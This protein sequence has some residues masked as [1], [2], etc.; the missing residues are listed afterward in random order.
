MLVLPNKVPAHLVNKRHAVA[1]DDVLSGV[2]RPLHP[3]VELV[4]GDKFDYKDTNDVSITGHPE[5]Q[6]YVVIVD[7]SPVVTRSYYDTAYSA[8]DSGPPKCMSDDGVIPAAD[9]LEPQAAFCATC[10]HNA[11]K[12]AR[13]GNGKACSERKKV[14]VMRADV[15]DNTVYLLSIPPAS[16]TPFAKYAREVGCRT[17][18]NRQADVSDIVTSITIRNKRMEFR[19]HAYIVPELAKAIE[20]AHD[21][22]TPAEVVGK[23]EAYEKVVASKPVVMIS[24]PKKEVTSDDLTGVFGERMEE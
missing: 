21:L 7:V 2:S 3:R 9:S 11:W 18:G 13:V 23:G 10:P 4:S 16:L 20:D 14:A 17:I 22:G 5:D 12:T 8:G 1:I 19:A 15:E 24:A 6:I